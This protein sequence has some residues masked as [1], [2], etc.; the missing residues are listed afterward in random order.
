MTRRDFY[1][2]VNS[3]LKIYHFNIEEYQDKFYFQKKIN[4]RFPLLLH[5]EIFGAINNVLDNK[6]S[7]S[8]KEYII[9][10]TDKLYDILL[11]KQGNDSPN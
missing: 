1:G 5:E 3:I 11:S 6:D 4:E 2:E 10:V 7:L 8:Q 9:S